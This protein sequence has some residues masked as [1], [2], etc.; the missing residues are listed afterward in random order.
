MS[1]VQ[2]DLLCASIDLPTEVIEIINQKTETIHQNTQLCERVSNMHP[3]I[4]CICVSMNVPT[5]ILDNI[6]KHILHHIEKHLQYGGILLYYH[7]VSQGYIIK[8]SVI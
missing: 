2:T 4:L 7:F 1:I 5:N 3:D 6:Q 8:Y